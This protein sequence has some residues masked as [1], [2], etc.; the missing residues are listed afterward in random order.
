[1][2]VT[3]AGEPKMRM[4]RIALLFSLATLAFGGQVQAQTVDF[5]TM[6]LNGLATVPNSNLLSLNES[7]GSEASSAFLPTAFDTTAGVAGSF[8]F[9]LSRNTY[10]QSGGV[11]LLF[12]N[13]P[14]GAHALGNNGGIIGTTGIQN[15]VGIGLQSQILNSATIFTSAE[16]P[17]GGS[18]TSFNVPADLYESFHLAF[19]YSG[20]VLSYTATDSNTG[21][22]IASTRMIT[23][24][25]NAF[26]GFT[27]GTDA[28]YALQSVTNFTLNTTP[29]PEPESWTMMIAGMSLLGAVLCRRRGEN[30]FAGFA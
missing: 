3:E 7:G 2:T 18:I 12:Q 16:G 11:A 9:I 29:V 19:S 25:S 10:S 4:K 21:Q 24:P 14:A 26:I 27:S 5:T 15:A 30:R 23:L 8:D 20:G 17:Y 6:T 13:D 1:M 22:S 28:G